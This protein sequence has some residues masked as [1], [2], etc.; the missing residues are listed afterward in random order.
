[1]AGSFLQ[2]GYGTVTLMVVDTDTA[3]LMSVAVMVYP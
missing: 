1:M 3:E 2:A